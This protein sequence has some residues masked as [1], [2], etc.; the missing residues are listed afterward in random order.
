MA[1]GLLTEPLLDAQG[2]T[3][4][5]LQNLNKKILSFTHT[6]AY[7]SIRMHTYITGG[8]LRI[9]PLSCEAA[10]QVA[11]GT[12]RCLISGD[13]GQSLTT[14]TAKSGSIKR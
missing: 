6:C 4:I 5:F 7:M 12:Y 8:S 14:E 11:M 10:P 9:L 1:V 13:A 2:K 3:L